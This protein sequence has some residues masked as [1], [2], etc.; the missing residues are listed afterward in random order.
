MTTRR[1]ARESISEAP[2]SSGKKLFEVASQGETD[3]KGEPSTPRGKAKGKGKSKSQS[4]SPKKERR[5]SDSRYI[6]NDSDHSGDEDVKEDVKEE[7]D[8]E[9]S[10]EIIPYTQEGTPSTVGRKKRKLGSSIGHNSPWQLERQDVGAEG[11]PSASGNRRSKKRAVESM[12]EPDVPLPV[13]VGEKTEEEER[14]EALPALPQPKG[15]MSYIW[16]FKR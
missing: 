14:E 8:R 3:V 10:A 9:S 2:L 5:G 13:E 12:D 7:T 6:P 15:W 11:S 16:P 1:R 4:K